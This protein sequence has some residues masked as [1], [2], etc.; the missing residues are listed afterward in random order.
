MEEQS[1]LLIILGSL[2]AI[3]EGLA[4]I[5]FFKSN[6]VFQFVFGLLKKVKDLFVKKDELK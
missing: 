5:P 6:S 3:S 1:T 2:L 4:L